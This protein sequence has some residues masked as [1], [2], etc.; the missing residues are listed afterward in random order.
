MRENSRI[1]RLFSAAELAGMASNIPGG[2]GVFE[3][4]V[5]ARQILAP[6]EKPAGSTN[7]QS[8]FILPRA[9]GG[10]SVCA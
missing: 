8:R 10:H 3:S 7:L 5:A 9:A 6:P 4:V 2:L 1:H